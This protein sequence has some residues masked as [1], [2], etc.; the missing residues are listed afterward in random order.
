MAGANNVSTITACYNT[1]NVSGNSSVGGVAGQKTM[2]G[3]I[4]ACYWANFEGPGTAHIDNGMNSDTTKFGDG[5]W[6]S[7]GQWGT[8]GGGSGHY[9]KNLGGW[10]SPPVYPK[11]YWEKD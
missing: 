3:A 1:G 6:P 4:T 8:G 2:D 5:K 9:W 7:G 11:L 10:G